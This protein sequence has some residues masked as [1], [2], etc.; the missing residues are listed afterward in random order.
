MSAIIDESPVVVG[1]WV[2]VDAVVAL[3]VPQCVLDRGLVC[4]MLH[5]IQLA[6]PKRARIRRVANGAWGIRGLVWGVSGAG[7]RMRAG[8]VGLVTDGRTRCVVGRRV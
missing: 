5:G 8:R 3:V 6:R 4:G 2:G 7:G 1:S